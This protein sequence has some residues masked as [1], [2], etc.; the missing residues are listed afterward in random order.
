MPLGDF[1]SRMSESDAFAVKVVKALI[2]LGGTALLSVVVTGL[3]HRF[4]K[5]SMQLS[6]DQS[7]VAGKELE[8]QADTLAT[9][10]KRV[11]YTA[12]WTLGVALAV[13]ALGFDIW[14]VLAGAGVAGI[15]IG[16][17]AQSILKD[18]ISGFFLLTEGQIRINDVIRIGELAGAVEKMTLRTIALRGFD[19][20]L[21]VIANGSVT[22]FS[23]LT[24]LFSYAV[25]EISVDY[26]DDPSR[27]MDIMSEVEQEMRVD[28]AIGQAILEPM[29]IVG[30]DKFLEAGVVIKAR[31]KTE[32]GQQWAVTREFNRRLKKRCDE[33][34]V[35][36]ATARRA[37]RVFSKEEPAEALRRMVNDPQAREELKTFMCEVGRE[38]N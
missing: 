24:L 34:G 11:A 25:F 19:G 30:V 26:G 3:I 31:L 37:V 21:H 27:M 2:Y 22:T 10:M 23:N 18:W 17:A 33:L 20:A 8:K 36:I 14:P 12:I 35:I 13:G 29:E 9:L 38:G 1:V 5:Y 6:R 7:R 16:F 15:A 4:R 32:P 28:P